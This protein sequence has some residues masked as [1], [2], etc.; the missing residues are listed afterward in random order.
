MTD[1]ELIAR[2]VSLAGV[3]RCCL[4]RGP[5]EWGDPK[6]VEGSEL[7]CPHGCDDVMVLQGNVWRGRIA[8][9]RAKGVGGE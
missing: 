5:S 2:K 4:D 3:F 9:M 6:H 7:P 8:A 1:T